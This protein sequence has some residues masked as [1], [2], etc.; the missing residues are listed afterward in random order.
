[1]IMIMIKNAIFLN[2]IH[3]ASNLREADEQE[4]AFVWI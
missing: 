1:M 2:T 4:C 3:N